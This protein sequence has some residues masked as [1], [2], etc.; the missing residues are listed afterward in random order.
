MTISSSYNLRTNLVKNYQLP[1]SEEDAVPYGENRMS[2]DNLDT[3]VLFKNSN[4]E[5]QNLLTISHQ[6]KIRKTIVV[7]NR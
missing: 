3:L 4:S 6:R 7:V 2:F 5:F 1:F